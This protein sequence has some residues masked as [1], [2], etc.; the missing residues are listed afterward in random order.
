MRIRHSGLV[1]ESKFPHF[2]FWCS[3]FHPEPASTN[4][5][6]ALSF[7]SGLLGAVS[8]SAFFFLAYSLTRLLLHIA[9]FYTIYAFRRARRAKS[10][11]TNGN[12]PL[13]CKFRPLGAVSGPLSSCPFLFIV[14]KYQFVT[15]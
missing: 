7:K 3:P 8:A 9:L 14:A 15:K 6:S 11:S 4:G 12:S 5:N 2:T 13:S 1:S 10:A